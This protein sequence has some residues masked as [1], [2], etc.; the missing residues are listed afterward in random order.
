MQSPQSLVHHQSSAD[1]RVARGSVGPP[2]T[3][4]V[5]VRAANHICWHSNLE[6]LLRAY[7]AVWKCPALPSS[8]LVHY[9]ARATV[10]HFRARVP[11]S[12]TGT[13]TTDSHEYGLLEQGAVQAIQARPTSGHKG[14]PDSGAC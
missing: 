2:N 4:W 6:S 8:S 13:R 9:A 1:T 14:A 12:E 5:T 3:T 7:L 11:Q 10:A